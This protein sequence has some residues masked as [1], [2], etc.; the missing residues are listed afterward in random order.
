MTCFQNFET[1]H[2]F[3]LFSQDVVLFPLCQMFSFFLFVIDQFLVTTEKFHRIPCSSF[4]SSSSGDILLAVPFLGPG[5]VFFLFQAKG[6]VGAEETVLFCSQFWS[7]FLS[8]YPPP[9][10]RF[11]F[12]CFTLKEQF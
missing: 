2:S 1:N 7:Y 6:K 11:I 4:K 5:R 9:P 12:G 8:F 10:P 3:F